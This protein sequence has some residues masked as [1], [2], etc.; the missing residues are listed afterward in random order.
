MHHEGK[1]CF[2]CG[3]NDKPFYERYYVS[4]GTSIEVKIQK[5]GGKLYRI[6]PRSFEYWC[7]DCYNNDSSENKGTQK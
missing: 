3:K 6:F 5:I 4:S 2:N 1:P 7:A